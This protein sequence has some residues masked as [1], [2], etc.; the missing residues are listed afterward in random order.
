MDIAY[1]WYNGTILKAKIPVEAPGKIGNY[2][3]GPP[4]GSAV[5]LDLRLSHYEETPRWI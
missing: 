1:E 2:Y 3:L 5:M 4:S